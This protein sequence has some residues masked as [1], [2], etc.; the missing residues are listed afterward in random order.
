MERKKNFPFTAILGQERMKEALVLNLV[1][2]SIGGVLIRG[3][4]GTAKTTA[5]RGL[6]DVLPPLKVVELPINATEDRV[7]GTLDVEYALKTGEKR[8][9]PGILAQADRQI[10]YVDEIN[11]LDDHIVDLLLDAAATGVNT[12]EREGISYSH[13][14]RFILV[15]TMNPEEGSLRPQLL[16]R[17]GMVV[18]VAGETDEEVRAQIIEDRLAYEENPEKF[19]RAHAKERKALAADIKAAKERLPGV[20]VSHELMLLAAQIGIALGTEGHRADISMV[21]TAKTIAAFRGSMEADR[22]DLKKAALYTLPHRMRKGPLD[23]G[24]M[25]VSRLDEIMAAYPE[26]HA[27]ENHKKTAQKR[28]SGDSSGMASEGG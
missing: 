3:Q 9:E 6:S 15:G 16:D 1:N 8:F 25:D 17:F 19:C 11:L 28:E 12:V 7:A 20:K 2:P 22:E 26:P 27:E 24:Q 13:P 5:V 14:S 4:K 18:D 21:K 23:T 10:L